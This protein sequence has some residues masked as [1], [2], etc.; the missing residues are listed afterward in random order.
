M[1]LKLGDILNRTKAWPL[2]FKQVTK[3]QSG[4][5]RAN[6]LLRIEVS[7]LA[8]AANALL[9]EEVELGQ[10]QASTNG[11][12]PSNN[13]VEPNFIKLCVGIKKDATLEAAL[14]KEVTPGAF[15]SSPHENYVVPMTERRGKDG[16]REEPTPEER[17]E[18]KQKL[19]TFIRKRF[20]GKIL[21]KLLNPPLKWKIH[22][23]EEEAMAEG[24]TWERIKGLSL[25]E[26]GS[27]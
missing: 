9:N 5:K 21:V 26:Y 20:P 6:E 8:E 2:L 1:K 23:S 11:S 24:G 10:A 7:E 19:E 25:A 3:I 4:T 17:Q 22:D 14:R 12:P 13:T 15:W 18:I 16:Q 27:P